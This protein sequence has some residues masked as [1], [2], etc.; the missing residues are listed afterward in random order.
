M[1]K[2]LISVFIILAV[3]F[4]FSFSAAGTAFAA[5]QGECVNVKLT[6]DGEKTEAVKAYYPSYKYNAYVSLEDL[7]WALKGTDKA[8]DVQ[9]V[10][11]DWVVTTGKDYTGEEPVPFETSSLVDP[12]VFDDIDFDAY[13]VTIDGVDRELRMYDTYGDDFEGD[14]AGIYVRLIDLGM[15]FNLPIEYQSASKMTIDT[16]KNFKIDMKKIESAEYFHDLDGV[17]LGDVT[18]G[19]KL[20]AWDEK[21]STEIASTSKLMTAAIVFDEIKAGKLSM[22]TTYT[23]S[24]AA[25]WEANS[26]DGTLYADIPSRGKVYMKVGQ[27]WSVH[28]LMCAMLLPSANEAATALAEAVSGSE[29]KFVK[30][31]NEKAKE[32]GLKSA[33]FYNPHGLPN[34][35]DSQFT[36]KRQNHMSAEDMYKLCTY[37]MT[38]YKDELV[39][40]TGQTKQE[41]KSL[42]D[43]VYLTAEENDGVEVKYGDEEGYTPYV[44]TTYGTLFKNVEGLI[45]LKTGTTNRSGACI[46]TAIDT[47]DA[48]GNMHTIVSVSF[49]GEDNRQ[50]YESSTVLLNYA[51]QQVAAQKT[52]VA[53]KA[54]K[55]KANGKNA[56]KVS[57]SGKN[58]VKLNYAGYEV[59]R[60][61]KKSSGYGTKPV[62]TTAKKSFVDTK[63]KSGTKY[64]YKVRGFNTVNGK[65]EYSGWSK[66]A[67][68]A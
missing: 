65:K 17:Y 60:S 16:S 51:K 15:F 4:T 10:D 64:Y 39:A 27:T 8:F 5:D 45:G 30:K 68:T 3:M 66:T 34:Y 55:T 53:V 37:L 44:T 26:E 2:R 19:K 1:K 58:S 24:K 52:S 9:N 61:V 25:N 7:A 46:V 11:G 13:T 41:L 35:T 32:L 42:A 21:H 48:S 31:M 33:K 20:Y 54:A 28:D 56:V 67:V 50:R 29:A 63:V 6:V 57:W 23:V 43:D 14:V 40:I 59:F 36:G 38:N 49:G 47:P 62:T 18:T 12:E 22:D